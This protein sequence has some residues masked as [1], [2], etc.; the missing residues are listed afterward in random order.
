MSADELA[1]AKRAIAALRLPIKPVPTRRFRPDQL[2]R[3]ID[4]RATLR[5][6]LR[7]SGD[8]M[9]LKRRSRA[10]RLPT[11]V[12]LC[13]VS[14]SMSRYSRMFLH[15]V[16]AVTN[17]RDRVAQLPLRYPAH[18]HHALSQAPRRRCR[19][20]QREPRRPRLVRRHADRPLPQ[21][22][23]S[24]LVEACAG[25]GRAGA[26]DHGRAGPRRSR[27][28]AGRGGAA[29]QVLPAAHLAQPAA[30]LRGASKPE[31]GGVRTILPHIDDFRAGP[32]H[33]KPHGHRRR[34][35]RARQR[36]SKERPGADQDFSPR[37][38]PESH[39]AR[40]SSPCEGAG[41]EPYINFVRD[42]PGLSG[43]SG[44]S[45][46]SGILWGREAA[47]L[48]MGG[49]D[50]V[51]HAPRVVRAVDGILHAPRVVRAVDGILHAPRV[52]RAV[53]GILHAPRV[54]RAVDGILH[55]PRVVR[56]VDGILHAPHHA[57][58]NG[59][60]RGR[61]AQTT[62]P[63]RPV[64]PPKGEGGTQAAPPSSPSSPS[65]PPP[66]AARRESQASGASA[67]RLRE[68]NEWRRGPG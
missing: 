31:A 58:L 38:L 45:G 18:Q 22:L 7:S 54:V 68:T 65:S 50:G 52:V 6:S 66:S 51:A 32:Q 48:D 21:G 8:L 19:R 42:S 67:R 11:L 64:V 36:P 14:G 56:A 24:I 61:V 15:F 57:S 35:E 53:D 4:M 25:P 44:I 26:A 34:A 37:R 12:V 62:S 47:V 9:P 2:G 49:G 3:R 16:H 41:Y 17:D 55:A 1:E 39:P 33:C 46:I 23:Q 20:R 63:S 13:D 40:L 30:P 5:A 60:A 59:P 27:H 29:A 28:S 43:L 10:K